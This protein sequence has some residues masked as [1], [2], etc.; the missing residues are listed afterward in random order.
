M[1]KVVILGISAILFA[2]G[3]SSCKKTSK[4]K[5][6]NDWKINKMELTNA[7]EDGTK[8]ETKID[9]TSGTQVDSNGDSYT[10]SVG[11][12]TWSIKKDGSWTRESDLTYNGENNYKKHVVSTEEGTWSFLGKNK[13]QKFKKNELIV[14]TTTK[15][16]FEKTV[17][18]TVLGQT[19][20]TD[21]TS[22]DNYET[23]GVAYAYRVID[24]KKKELHLA[25]EGKY[26]DV[27]V[28]GSN[29]SSSSDDYSEHFYLVK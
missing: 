16:T 11:K 8:D 1:K 20:T 4:G 21:D 6:S 26:N 28:N 12:M 18:Q 22:V 15:S 23:G 9:G 17:T 2:G 27:S 10:I 14:F 5:V 25:L 24:S 19:T 3:V 13:D 7:Y 29:S